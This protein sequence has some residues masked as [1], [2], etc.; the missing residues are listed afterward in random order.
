MNARTLSHDHRTATKSGTASNKQPAIGSLT[1]QLRRFHSLLFSLFFFFFK[2]AVGRHSSA[3][4]GCSQW[5]TSAELQVLRGVWQISVLLIVRMPSGQTIVLLLAAFVL[6]LTLMLSV[7]DMY[8]RSPIVSGMTPQPV[9]ASPPARRLVLFVGDGVRADSFFELDERGQARAPYMRRIMHTAGAWGV[10]HTHVPTESRPGHVALIAGFYEDVSA[11]TKGWKEN[12]VEFDSLFNESRQTWS[13][14]S[15]DILPMFSKG[16]RANRVHTYTYPAEV[17]DFGTADA[18]SLDV[19]VFDRVH[20]FLDKAEGDQELRGQLDQDGVVLFLHLLGCDTNGHGHRPTSRQYLDNIRLVDEGV[21]NIS[22]HVEKLFGNDGKTAFIFTADHGMTD[23]GA[24]GSGHAHETLTPLVAWGAGVSGPG[25]V[26]GFESVDDRTRYWKLEDIK[27]RDVEQADVAPL[28]A[29]LI[30]VPMP[31]NNV[32]RLPLEYLNTSERY[33]A[34]SLLANARQI[35]EQF[36]VTASLKHAHLPDFLFVPF[37]KLPASH[38]ADELRKIDKLIRDQDYGRA[39]EKSTQLVSAGLEGLRYYQTYDRFFIGTCVVLGMVGLM[40]CILIEVMSGSTSNMLGRNRPGTSRLLQMPFITLAGCVFI[41]LFLQEAPLQYYIYAVL[42]FASFWHVARRWTTVKDCITTLLSSR[43][44]PVTLMYF[45]ATVAGLELLVWSF[46]HRWLLSIG[47]ILLGIWPLTTP[48]FHRYSTFAWMVTCWVL[49]VFPMLPVVGHE[50]SLLL[51]NSAALLAC[52]IVPISYFLLMRSANLPSTRNDKIVALMQY[53][54]LLVA[55]YVV[56]STAL[57]RQHRQ[58]LDMEHTLSWSLLAIAPLLPTLASNAIAV[59][60]HGLA[61]AAFTIYILM[62]TSYEALFLLV[63][64]AALYSWLTAELFRSGHGQHS[65]LVE[66]SFADHFLAHTLERNS[67]TNGS[68]VNHQQRPKEVPLGW[69]EVRAALFFV[70]FSLVAFFGTGNI[71]SLNTFNI[72]SVYTFITVFSP[73]VMSILLFIKILLPLVLVGCAFNAVHVVCRVPARELFALSLVMSDFLA[74]HFFFLV[75]D[76]GSWLDIGTSISHY[77]MAMT[78]T[79]ALLVIFGLARL[80]T[81]W[82]CLGDQRKAH[83]E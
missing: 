48:R 27:R 69:Q 50:P 12:P 7:F 11:V 39:M 24:H 44:L 72:S 79:L 76:F 78:L 75:R 41:L 40:L 52:V 61:T 16:A 71:A 25:Q 56:N 57:G 31:M 8:F 26:T 53:G 37:S 30:G 1:A 22:A 49:S 3:F 47:L 43:P 14:G 2:S 60:L 20:A 67:S 74:L 68:P 80:A 33:K 59:R 42:P 23:W 64:S 63:L 5:R 46:F 21:R 81:T 58:S 9:S 66:R 73:F 15:P 19:W 28:M 62:S 18:S 35:L 32:G 4:V 77:V 55:V 70:F 54:L 83:G 10:S 65:L 17:E 45:V 38:I 82:C 51:V 34:I 13:W 36:K 6:H 29:A